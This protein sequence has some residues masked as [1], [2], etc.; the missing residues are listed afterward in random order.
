M[1]KPSQI[2]DPGLQPERTVFAWTRTLVSFL[3]V[4]AVFL[5]WL[6]HYGVGIVAMIAVSGTMAFGI[7]ASQRARYHRMSF[8]VKQERISAD[9]VAVLMTT[10]ALLVLGVFGLILVLTPR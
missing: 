8:G 2:A 1:N 7:F 6:P 4:S 5:R 3:V 10:T 9:I